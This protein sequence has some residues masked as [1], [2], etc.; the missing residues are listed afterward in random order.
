MNFNGR[1]IVEKMTCFWVKLQLV[2]VM[3]I[4]FSEWS[5]TRTTK[6]YY[7]SLSFEI[8]NMCQKSEVGSLGLQQYLLCLILHTLS[9]CLSIRCQS[10]SL[11]YQVNS[12][13]LGGFCGMQKETV[14]LSIAI[15][16]WLALH[17]LSAN[18][19]LFIWFLL[20]KN[21]GF[22]VWVWKNWGLWKK[23]MKIQIHLKSSVIF[24]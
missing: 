15:Y 3:C 12:G 13:L 20:V 1:N 16:Q 18:D 8:Q 17:V 9:I 22:S 14:P 21:P 2:I 24:D 19:V 4:V 5:R 11:M 6:L 10:V 23:I 7:R